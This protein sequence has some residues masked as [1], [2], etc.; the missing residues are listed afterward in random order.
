MDY[1]TKVVEAL[2]D[3]GVEITIDMKHVDQKGWSV[4][5]LDVDGYVLHDGH[6]KTF[7]KATGKSSPEEALLEINSK[8]E[9]SYDSLTASIR[10]V[11]RR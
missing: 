4:R 11:M 5:L 1:L 8:L 7:F 2:R 9:N 3:E 6:G 10:S